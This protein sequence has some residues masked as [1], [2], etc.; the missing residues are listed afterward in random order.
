MFRGASIGGII[1]ITTNFRSI[2]NQQS[3]L[4]LTYLVSLDEILRMIEPE[5]TSQIVIDRTAE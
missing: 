3:K 2:T 5:S 1:Q 4:L